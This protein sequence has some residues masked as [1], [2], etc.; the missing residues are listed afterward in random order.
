MGWNGM[1]LGLIGVAWDGTADVCIIQLPYISAVLRETLRLCPTIPLFGRQAKED[2]IIGGKYF[3]PKDQV[4]FLLLAKSH[5]DPNVFGETANEFV[6]ER[7]LDEN[8]ERLVQQYP[9][10][11]KP[12]GTG[13]RS[14]IGRPFAWQEAILVM[15]MLLQNFDYTLHDP[16]YELQYKQTL[17]TK[18]KGFYM[19]AKLRD[20]LTAT[21][22]EHRL[23]GSPPPA[24]SRPAAASRA[25]PAAK[26]RNQQEA[27]PIS[28][29]YGSNTGTC[30]SLAQILA[31]SAG[32]HGFAATIVEPLDAATGALPTDRPVVIITASYE[33]QPPD[34]AASFCDWLQRLE[35]EEL[36][37]VPYAV[38]GCGHHDWNQTFHRIPTLVDQNMDARGGSRICGIGLTDVANGD[39]FTDFEQWED[40]VFWPA[41]EARYAT[42]GA[43]REDLSGGEDVLSVRISTPRSSTLRQDVQA[44]TVVDARLL[45][46]PGA[47]PKKHM[48]IQ[49]PGETTYKVGDY[50]TV[51]PVNPKESITW[52]MRHFQLCWDS[53]VTIAA[54]RWTSLPTNTP[55]PVYDVLGSYVE[56]A[57]PATK[58]VRNSPACPGRCTHNL[59]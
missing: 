57:Q 40:D 49:L 51:L 52:A 19:R 35:G 9:D 4:L 13:M 48:E 50:L 7:M 24:N 26:A 11:W 5:M 12:F 34:D 39:M 18:P 53:H 54:D 55:V 21:E 14:C 30:E 16:S 31:T 47:A 44:A 3:V 37:N 41:M 45:T 15:A 46:A 22:L 59:T 17:T 43:G 2:Q 36:A 1:G 33:G 8:F 29:F 58:R 56:L 38:F 6:P 42:G 10:C 28:I 32:S 23:A 27:I 20:G 25:S